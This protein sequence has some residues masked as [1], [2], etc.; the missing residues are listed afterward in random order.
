MFRSDSGSA[1]LA[2]LINIALATLITLSVMAL[3]MAGYYTLV[4]RDLAVEAA[5]DLATYGSPNQREYLLKRL[6][7]SLP[8]LASLDVTEAKSVDYAA[9]QVRFGLPGLGMTGL[10]QGQINVQA[11]TERL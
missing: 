10:S 1:V 2:G 11:A 3:G 9:I 8:E 5:T 7:Y 6:R 4:I